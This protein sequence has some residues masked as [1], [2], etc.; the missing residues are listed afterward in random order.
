MI[1]R[2]DRLIAVFDGKKGGTFNTILMAHEKGIELR[3]L[4]PVEVA[5]TQQNEPQ[6][7]PNE[8]ELKLF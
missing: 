1:D 6:T 8:P 7:P 5:L 3:I 4:S 2:A